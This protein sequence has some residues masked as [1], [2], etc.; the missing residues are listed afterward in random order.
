M[1][2]LLCLALL[3]GGVSDARGQ[4]VRVVPGGIE[5]EERVGVAS[6]PGDVVEPESDEEGEGD[7]MREFVIAP[8]PSRIPLLG[9]TLA[10]PAVWLYQPEFSQP[11]DSV[12]VTGGA[13]FYSENKSYGGGLFHKMSLGGDQWR[14]SGAAFTTD[15][16]YDFF[17]IGGSP[18]RRIPLTQELDFL[19]AEGLYRVAPNLYAGLKVMSAQTTT[20]IDLPEDLLP[21]GVSPPSLTLDLDLVTLGPK[22]VFDTRDNP[23]YP[24]GGWLLEGS[25]D[26]GRSGIG[27]DVDY[28]RHEW[29]VNRYLAITDRGTLAFRAVTQY[30]GGDA[31]FF[32]VPAFGAG[33]DLRGYET[34]TYRDRFLFAAQAEWR[35]RL[36]PRWG[37]VAFAGIGT[38]APDFARW[39]ETLPSGGVGIRWVAAPKN[40]LSLR[41]D[42]AWGR[43]ES[44]FYVSIGEAF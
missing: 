28:E 27:S 34:G 23:F 10:V 1:P 41:V 13:A 21:P 11:G 16:R 14:F 44:E 36:S 22:L 29:A 33:S 3:L 24:R 30:V 32:V 25:L 4:D 5:L 31:P 6:V 40:N 19:V 38:V 7:R 17:G 35:Q 9:W 20:G 18:D 12:W 2:L 26:V 42:V 15:L 8:L 37:A 39:G 43:G